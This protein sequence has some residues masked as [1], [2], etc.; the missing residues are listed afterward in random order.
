MNTATYWL[1]LALAAAPLCAQSK[2]AK[3]ASTRLHAAWLR[4]IVDL[5]AEGAAAD[6]RSIATDFPDAHERWIAIARLEELRRVGVR[7]GPPV[8]TTGAPTD[9]VRALQ[10]LTPLPMSLEE[11]QRQA[12]AGPVVNTESPEL[13]AIPDLRPASTLAQAWVIRNTGPTLDER[14]MQRMQALWQQRGGGNR[15]ERYRVADAIDVLKNEMEGRTTLARNLRRASFPTFK[16]L[17]PKGDATTLLARARGN[18]ETWIKEGMPREQA[19]LLNRLLEDLKVTT[20]PAAALAMLQRL[21]II[22]ERLLAEP[23]AAK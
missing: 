19:T 23:A 1:A 10:K 16:D 21:P 22:G 17:A 6:Y 12:L 3:S 18:L 20:N 9:I 13:L 4:E 2:A 8:P 7:V 14:S 5:D 15:S 11:L